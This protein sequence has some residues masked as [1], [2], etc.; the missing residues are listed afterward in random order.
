MERNIDCVSY[1]CLFWISTF[2]EF[3]KAQNVSALRMGANGSGQ[4]AYPS[5]VESQRSFFGS[6]TG[7]YFTSSSTELITTTSGVVS[8]GCLIAASRDVD[9]SMAAMP[10]AVAIV[11]AM[12]GCRTAPGSDR[13][14]NPDQMKVE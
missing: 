9:P 2:W 14:K 5:T 6:G 12:F 13:K 1:Q 10:R 4:P 7:L 3:W 11:L 8:L